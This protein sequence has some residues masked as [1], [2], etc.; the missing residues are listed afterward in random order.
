MANQGLMQN[1]VHVYL[2]R[3]ARAQLMDLSKHKHAQ[4]N[5]VVKNKCSLEQTQT[6]LNLARKKT[7][8]YIRYILPKEE[9]IWKIFY[10][11]VGKRERTIGDSNYKFK[12]NNHH[13]IST[14]WYKVIYVTFYSLVHIF[15]ETLRENSKI[16]NNNF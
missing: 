7:I 9:I 14:H 3:E 1:K 11:L 16:G 2:N 10:I 5:F 12:E 8:W 15:V 6:G 13:A 4:I